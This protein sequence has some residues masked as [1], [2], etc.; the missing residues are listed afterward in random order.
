[1]IMK[2]HYIMRRQLHMA[3]LSMGVA[4]VIVTLS[5]AWV[6]S[7]WSNTADLTI[8]TETFELGGNAFLSF[9]FSS[10]PR[11][12]RYTIAFFNFLPDSAAW[13]LYAAYR[14][15]RCKQGCT[16]HTGLYA[17]Y[18]AVRCIQGCTLHT[19]LYAAYRAVRCIQGHG[20]WL[21]RRGCY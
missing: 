9:I 5:R 20:G 14:A 18:R 17:A 3:S 1:M 10:D 8:L 11:H 16:L 7:W 2:G 21:L 19:G 6:L 4:I 15:V 12:Y 13:K